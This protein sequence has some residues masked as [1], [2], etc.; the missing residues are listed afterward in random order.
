MEDY[1]KGDGNMMDISFESE[2]SAQDQS[3]NAKLNLK[4]IKEDASESHD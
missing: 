3:R 2:Q 4:S 1:K